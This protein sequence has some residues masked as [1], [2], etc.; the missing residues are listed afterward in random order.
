MAT[1]FVS[2]R[3]LTAGVCAECRPIVV[4]PVRL[5]APIVVTGALWKEP[6][7]DRELDQ[8]RARLAAVEAERDAE[9]D[10]AFRFAHD[11]G[12]SEAGRYE[13]LNE[14]DA[15]LAQ[16]AEAVGLLRGAQP[17][18]EFG[19]GPRDWYERR[20]AFLARIDGPTGATER[21]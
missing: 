18:P 17:S 15:A 21:R 6:P 4:T 8:L 13:A 9:R 19:V 12:V 20:R 10:S 7:A 14:R 16:L 2:C 11:A 5:C 1:E 3:H